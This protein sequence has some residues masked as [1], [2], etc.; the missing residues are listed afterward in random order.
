MSQ[1]YEAVAHWLESKRAEWQAAQQPETLLPH[2]VTFPNGAAYSCACDIT[3]NHEAVSITPE[4]YA[5][6][7]QDAALTAALEGVAARE[8]GMLSSNQQPD[9]DSERNTNA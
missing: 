9:S 6:L 1:V 3:E 2:M 4:Q 5:K 8:A 7:I